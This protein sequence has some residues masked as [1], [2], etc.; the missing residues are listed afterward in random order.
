M[1]K[2]YTVS[3]IESD[4]M[5]PVLRPSDKV[6]IKAVSSASL[7]VGDIIVYRK[8]E[9]S[10]AHRI[11]RVVNNKGF[12]TYWTRGDFNYKLDQVST[13]NIIGKIAGVYRDGHL[14]PVR[15]PGCCWLFF[16]VFL[17]KEAS[18]RVLEGIYSLG[19]FRS[20]IKRLF[21]LKVS[22]V[23]VGDIKSNDDFKSFYHRSFDSLC[24]GGTQTG[25]MAL[26]KGKP[27][28]K[29]WILIDKEGSFF[30]YGPYV[31]LLYRVR[32]VA[33]G[34]I[35]QAVCYL[36]GSGL[37]RSKVYAFTGGSRILLN[38]FSR[39]EIEARGDFPDKL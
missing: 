22:Y 17:G 33:G 5:W 24:E 23:V 34:L 21:P 29:L 11:V 1:K 19:F 9:F 32:G 30:F 7:R 26:F 6:L 16:I 28:G 20:W 35:K 4:S 31:R 13:E 38:C 27:I 15:G 39:E 18:T 3:F 10:V 2:N 36:E 12:S 14:K 37:K 8:K 25:I